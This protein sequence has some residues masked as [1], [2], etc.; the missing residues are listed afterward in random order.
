MQ[1]S[2][3]DATNCFGLVTPLRRLWPEGMISLFMLVSGRLMSNWDPAVMVSCVDVC[4]VYFC[5]YRLAGLVK[6]RM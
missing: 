2:L 5:V 1:G 3:D 6:Q 4:W